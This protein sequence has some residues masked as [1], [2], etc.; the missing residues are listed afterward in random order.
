MIDLIDRNKFLK[1][2]FPE[3][4]GDN[5]M[6]GQIGL[7]LRD[8]CSVDIHT[9]Q[10][11]SKEVAK[12]GKWGEDFNVI[13]LE[14]SGSGVEFV[15]ITNFAKMDFGKTFFRKVDNSIV[16]DYDNEECQVHLK[17]R[18]LIFQQCR[19]YFAE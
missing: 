18:G 10:K 15:S 7:R 1:D 8:R 6:I 11:P 17:F 16:I 13:A 12:W 4:I 14:L 9:R 19:T 2:I 5:V 3:G